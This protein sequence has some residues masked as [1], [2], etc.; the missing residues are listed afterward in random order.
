MAGSSP[1]SRPAA[2]GRTGRPRPLWALVLLGLL[3][4]LGVAVFTALGVWQ[5]ERRAWKH[6]L[7]E[8]VEQRVHAAPAAAPGP[9][10][11]GGIDAAGDEYRRVA[12]TGRFLND[13]ETLVQAVS[14]LGAGF[15]V[16]TPFESREGFT[17]LVN[18]GFVP[19]NRRD[20]AARADGQIEGETTVTGLLRLTEPA[21]GF[22]RSNDPAADRW[23]SR[24]VAAIGAARGLSGLAPY[25]IDADGGRAGQNGAVRNG[26]VGGLTVIRFP[27]NH[28]V[29]ALTWFTLALM[30]L[31]G[32]AAVFLHERRLRRGRRQS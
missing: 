10:A 5:V 32:A 2:G 3:A 1:E 12:V 22:L 23:H 14:D 30:L 6:D 31:G 18:R 26:P 9:E 19:P 7:I 13:R 17:L 28:L 15:W 16:L 27:D 25:F 21:G 11:W 8:R 24:D 20:P 29:Y 4:A